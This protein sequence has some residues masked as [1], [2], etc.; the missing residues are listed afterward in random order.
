[1]VLGDLIADFVAPLLTIALQLLPVLNAAGT[2]GGYILGARARRAGAHTS[3]NA[4]PRCGSRTGTS[5]GWKL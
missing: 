4:G 3:G 2:I 1:M 5:S